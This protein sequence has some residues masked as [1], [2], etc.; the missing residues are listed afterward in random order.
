MHVVLNKGNQKG[1]FKHLQMREV[2]KHERLWKLQL[3]VLSGLSEK[4]DT[5]PLQMELG[6][7]DDI[8]KVIMHLQQ[9]K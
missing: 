9:I 2:P 3:N 1:Y 4:L 7:L 6:S 8:I 5:M